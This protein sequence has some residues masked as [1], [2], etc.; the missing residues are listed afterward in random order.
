MARLDGEVAMVTGGSRGIGLATAKHL[1]NAG[2]RVYLV[3]RDQAQLDAA[4]AELVGDVHALAADLTDPEAITTL[5][6]TLMR[7]EGRLDLL[8]NS[9]GQLEVG[10][11][12]SLDAATAEQLVSINY[13]APIRTITA[14]LPLLRAG[15]RRSIVNICSIASRLAPPRMAAYAGSKFALY[16]YSLA[17]RQELRGQG[18][19]VGLVFPGPVATEMTAGRLG[20]PHYPVPPGVPILSPETVARAI[21][22]VIKGRR[23]EI[24]VPRRL[25]VASRVFMLWPGGTDL[26]YRMLVRQ[27]SDADPERTA[28][29]G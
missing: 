12:E 17:L 16:G 7:Q 25:A 10:P 6:G 21:M 9:A 23:R 22:R 26:L 1:A 27:T 15:N 5:A 8:V 20:G 14:C 29:R 2:A 28:Q 19:H 13:L 3:A 18:F 4:V 11:A 24:T